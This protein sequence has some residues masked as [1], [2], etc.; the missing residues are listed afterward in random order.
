MTDHVRRLYAV[1]AGIL[2]LFLCWA[3]VAAH[4]WQASA[5]STEQRQ[6]AAL[7]RRELAI[8]REAIR[9]RGIVRR[10]WASYRV[11]LRHRELQIAAARSRHEAALAAARVAAAQAAAA[12]AAQASA[13]APAPVASAAAPVSAPAS[14]PVAAPPVRVVTLPPITV[15]R[16]S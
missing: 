2:L 4:P 11:A 3:A 14:A 10:R 8:R 12:S 15:T 16:T 7:H 13:S 5:R 1:A 9:V 6:L